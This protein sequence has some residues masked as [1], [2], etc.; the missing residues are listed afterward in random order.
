MPICS[1]KG[2]TN[3]VVVFFSHDKPE[4]ELHPDGFCNKCHDID[5]Q[6]QLDYWLFLSPNSHEE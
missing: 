3:E 2:C 4:G 5:V 6:Y 1:V